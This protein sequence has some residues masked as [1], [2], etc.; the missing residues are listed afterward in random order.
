MIH[1]LV[2]ALAANAGG[3]VT[4][5][6]N[7]VPHLARRDDVRTTV[8]LA[9]VLRQLLQPAANV[10][11]IECDF[12]SSSFARFFY[13]QKALPQL[14]RQHGADVLLAA[15]NFA[16]W[17]SPVPQILLSRNSLYTSP[18]YFQDLRRRQEYARWLDT[19]IK[20]KLAQRSIHR[21]EV[22]I[23]PSAAFAEDLR[24]WIGPSDAGKI[25]CIHHGFD[26]AAFHASPPAPPELAKQLA[27]PQRALRVL[28]VSNYTHYRNF[29]TL[30]RALP[31]IQS[32]IPSRRIE[33]V[34]T[35]KLGDD[36]NPGGYRSHEAASLRDRLNLGS[37]LV[38]L[39]AVPYS[40]LHHV[41]QASDIYVTPAYTETFAH[42]LVEAMSSGLPV[43]ASDLPV[44]REICAGA[45]NYFPRFSSELL[46]KEVARLEKDAELRS[47]LSQ[48]G[49][50]RAQEFSWARHVDSL[51]SVAATLKGRNQLG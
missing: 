36:V 13:E 2:N 15:G 8:V 26:A 41:Y 1:L 43:I 27:N 37:I 19:K 35:S 32:L 44:H 47:R 10:S 40:L 11:V 16:L 50:D 14:I 30:L 42:P 12:P 38:E 31:Q 23:A 46:A 9:P 22:T 18:D 45:A 28:F 7:V 51:L 4:Y 17:K 33:L 3:G 48:A 20:G 49:L 6:R 29:E 24:R 34:L 39:G 25:E 21:A 5:I